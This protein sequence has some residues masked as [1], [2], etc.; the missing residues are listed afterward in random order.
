MSHFTYVRTQL[1]ASGFLKKGLQDL[2]Y[3]VEEMC[4]VSGDQGVV[5]VDYRVT[6]PQGA[7]VGFV[8]K[9]EEEPYSLVADWYRVRDLEPT[10]FL[11]RLSQRYAYH[12]T[13]D[14]MERQGFDLVAEEKTRDGQIR[15][16]LRR[17]A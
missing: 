11:Q 8:R 15:L 6:T 3:A 1:V 2:G 4:T 5:R 10:D 16:T 7:Q 12:A 17:I 13:R 14:V 9:G